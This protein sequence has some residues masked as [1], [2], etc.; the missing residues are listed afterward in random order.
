MEK[1][2]SAM[3]KKLDETEVKLSEK[4]EEKIK[5][6]KN[7]IKELV[8]ELIGRVTEQEGEDR[9]EVIVNE[10]TEASNNLEWEEEEGEVSE[11]NTN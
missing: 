5:K 4:I 2:R 3:S 9:V 8:E 10:E 6:Q 7:E 11:N 1:F